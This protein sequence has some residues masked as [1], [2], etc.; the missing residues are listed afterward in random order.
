[1]DTIETL[2]ARVKL[3]EE[4]VGPEAYIDAMHDPVAPT[5]G[6]RLRSKKPKLVGATERVTLEI[7]QSLGPDYKPLSEWGWDLLLDFGAKSVKVVPPSLT[8]T[9][10]LEEVCKLVDERDSLK[11][12]LAEAEV[13][14][15]RH[16][17]DLEEGIA[18]RLFHDGNRVLSHE[19]TDMQAR[20]FLVTA[21]HLAKYLKET[22]G[23]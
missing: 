7:T 8:P 18:L 10:S 21:K 16:E 19:L 1:V 20:A 17:G 22:Y 13:R 15:K 14:L 12:K 11:K 23:L 6:K 2:A 5:S 3:L 9:W 4:L